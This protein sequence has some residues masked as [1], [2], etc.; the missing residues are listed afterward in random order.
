M[1]ASPDDLLRVFLEVTSN[2][3]VAGG[4]DNAFGQR[5]PAAMQIACFVA[6]KVNEKP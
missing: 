6:S 5:S 4:K 2:I 1:G 3:P